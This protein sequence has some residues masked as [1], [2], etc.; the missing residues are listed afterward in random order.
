MVAPTHQAP[1]CRDTTA[2]QTSNTNTTSSSAGPRPSTLLF[3]SPKPYEPTA[4]A[5]GP[6]TAPVSLAIFLIR[7]FV[8]IYP[9]E[10][11]V[12][13]TNHFISVSYFR[14]SSQN[15][16]ANQNP[17]DRI[18]GPPKPSAAP[19]A[20]EH[21]F[22]L[23]N[24]TTNTATTSTKPRR[25]PNSTFPLSQPHHFL[26]NFLPPILLTTFPRSTENPE[27]EGVGNGEIL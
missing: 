13:S 15:P 21:S 1:W 16:P 27:P 8:C 10:E 17:T 12:Y 18:S 7:F 9:R 11:A 23:C 2:P 25:T 3:P 19:V 6:D 5:R 20:Q 14:Q 22:P 24:T 4:P 26:L